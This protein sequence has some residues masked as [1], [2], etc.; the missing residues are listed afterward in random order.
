VNFGDMK[1][2][3]ALQLDNMPSDHPFYSSIGTALNQAANRVILMS[4]AKD[5]RA[6]NCFP[7]LRHTRRDDVT[8]DTEAQFDFPST[9]LVM[10]AAT[11]TQNSAAYDPST[12]REYPITEVPPSTF[13]LLDKSAKGWPVMW[14]RHGS[15]FSYWPTCSASPTDYRTRVIIYG[16]KKEN[17]LTSDSQSY[18]MN[19][20]WHPTVV[21]CATAIMLRNMREFEAAREM[22]TDVEKE[23]T[24]TL[25]LVGLE[26]IQ[27]KVS[28]SVAGTP[29]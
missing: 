29:R 3:V 4:F 5:R 24:A 15:K 21:A 2:A 6:G 9:L 23:V 17:D 25:N 11:C 19:E 1:T 18:V 28:L 12:Q 16:T 26:R 20:L 13:A 8:A 14:T 22:M 27:N 7:E 10:E